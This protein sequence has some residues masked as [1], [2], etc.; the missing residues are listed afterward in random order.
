MPKK[1]NRLITGE[2][3][4]DLAVISDVRISPSGE[5]VVYTQQ[6][7]DS[8]SE[9]KYSNLWIV[10]T[11]GGTPLQFTFGDQIDCQPRWSPNGET[12]A[13]LSDRADKEKQTKIYLIPF[14]GG[15]ARKLT[16]IQGKIG[17]FSWSPDGNKLLCKVRKTDQEILDRQKDE[18]KKELGTVKRHYDRV[19]YKLDD[20]GYLPH[21]RWHIW[22]V[23][24]KTGRGKQLTIHSIYEEIDPTWSPDGKLIAFMSNRRPCWVNFFIN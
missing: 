19:F 5:H 15:E 17:S 1:R 14:H 22:T 10:M 13:F 20:E 2:D 4:Y 12:I 24:V 3:L 9:K 23:S 16:D 18:Q 6:R 8:K 21:E 11:D 7:V